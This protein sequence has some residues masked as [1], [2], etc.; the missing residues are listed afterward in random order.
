VSEKGMV[1]FLVGD[2]TGMPEDFV[3]TF[4]AT[5]K[6]ATHRLNPASHFDSQNSAT[7]IN[8]HDGFVSN[9]KRK[10]KL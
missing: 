7:V 6:N 1:N 5:V 9:A 4:D 10:S 3:T 2:L 8:T